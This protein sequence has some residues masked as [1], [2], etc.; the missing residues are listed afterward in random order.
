MIRRRRRAVLGAACAAIAVI[1]GCSDSAPPG[2]S[3]AAIDR[4]RQ[5]YVAQ[6]IACHAPDPAQPGPLGP[7]TKGASRELLEAKVLRGTYP[8]GYTPK[9][10][11]M[12][13][14]PQPVLAGDIDALAAYLAGR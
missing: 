12:L 3:S 6:C 13:M 5:V 10:P 8:K 1:G 14:P 2:G 9:R 4:G 7:E 11:T